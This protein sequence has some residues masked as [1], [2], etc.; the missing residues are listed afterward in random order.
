MQLGDACVSTPDQHLALSVDAL[1]KAGCRKV[2]EE[3]A[4]GVFLRCFIMREL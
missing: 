1:R 4:I 2:Y 3:V